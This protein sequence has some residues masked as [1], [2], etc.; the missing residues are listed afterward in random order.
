[1]TPEAKVKKEIKAYLTSIGAY[2]FMPVQTGL[3]VKSIDFLCCIRGKF[4]GIEAKRPG[5]YDATPL[6][7]LTL[8]RMNKAGGLAFVTDS[9]ERTKKMIEDHILGAYDYARED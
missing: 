8:E 1:M 7:K 3:G 4:V 2:F 5:V 9:L 6:Q